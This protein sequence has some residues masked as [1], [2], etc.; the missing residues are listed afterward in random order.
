MLLRRCDYFEF[1]PDAQ[2]RMDRS[3][4][5][6]AARAPFSGHEGVGERSQGTSSCAAG[7]GAE[8]GAFMSGCGVAQKT[9]REPGDIQRR[10]MEEG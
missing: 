10:E 9:T 6:G 2:D 3:V 4:V 8:G 1:T 5:V 7:L